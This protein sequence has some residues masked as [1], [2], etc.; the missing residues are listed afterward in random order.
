MLPRER[1]AMGP[2][3]RLLL[4]RLLLLLPCVSVRALGAAAA[5]RTSTAPA[6]PVLVEPPPSV[7][8]FT[9]SSGAVVACLA[10]G[11]PSPQVAWLNLD[12]SPVTNIPSVRE[13]LSN[14]S[15]VVW[16]FSGTDYRQ[17]VHAAVYQ[18]RASNPAGVVLAP[19]TTLRAG[20]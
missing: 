8:T 13:V 19:P 2:R 7:V 18:C 6:G 4:L 15:L 14:G 5:V 11:D 10:R 20:K 1:V 16:P 3:L 9:N 17:D 12:H